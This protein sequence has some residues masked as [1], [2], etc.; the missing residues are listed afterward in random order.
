MSSVN[1][2]L[3]LE[4]EHCKDYSFPIVENRAEY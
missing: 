2:I 3:L 1:L 4:E